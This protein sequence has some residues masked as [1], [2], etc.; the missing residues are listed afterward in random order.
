MTRTLTRTPVAIVGGGPGRPD[1]QPPAGPRRHRV[2]RRRDPHPPRDRGDAPRRDPRAGQRPA[3]RRLRGLGPGAHARATSTRASTW[4]SGERGTASTSGRWSAPPASS[5]RRPRCSRTWPT[6]SAR[7]GGDVRFGV[8]RRVGRRRRVS[9]RPGVLFTD[10]DGVEHE[11][12]CDFLVGADGSRSTCRRAVPEP[13]RRQYFREYPFAWFGILCEAP[14]SAPELIYNHSETGFAL[15]SQ[16]TPTL[17]RMYFQCDP[18]RRRRRLVRRPDLGGAP[19]APRR[20]RAHPPRRGRSPPGRC[21]R[22][23]ASSR[24]PC[25]TAE[26]GAGRRRRAHGPAHRRQGPQ[27]RARRRPGA[28]RG[29][30]ARR[31]GTTTPPCSTTTR[32][33]RSGR[34]WKAQHFSYWMTTMLHSAPGRHALRRTPPGGRAGLARRLDAPGRPTSPRATPAGRPASRR[35]PGPPAGSAA[36]PRPGGS[37]SRRASCR[38]RRSWRRRARPWRARPRAG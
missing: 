14:A 5:T 37:S 29:A 22:S 1:A 9:D 20:Q 11:L 23:A 12:R 15:I 19:V 25:G 33:A 27:P 3:A 24:S 10:A 30:R 26:P 6:P 17:Q 7:D 8:A 28:G 21:C 32:P 16:R 36:P 18:G 38:S 34:V 35:G 31:P 4:P 13:E 2:R